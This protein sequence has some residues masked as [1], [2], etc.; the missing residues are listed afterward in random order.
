MIARTRHN[1]AAPPYSLLAPSEDGQT[2]R[3]MA[4]KRRPHK[5]TELETVRARDL[6]GASTHFEKRLWAKLRG[7][8][9]G[10]RKFRRQVPIAAFVAD[11]ACLEASL[12]IEL[13]G[14]QHGD[15]AERDARRTAPLK[16][17]GFRWRRCCTS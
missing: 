10:G 9:F 16:R 6:R 14:D 8:Q 11:F 15:T 4:G 1:S 7:R 12:I 3:R 2:D 5:Q 17:A 13:D